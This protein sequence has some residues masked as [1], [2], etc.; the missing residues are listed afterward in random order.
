MLVLNGKSEKVSNRIKIVVD[1]IRSKADN[2][3]V[4]DKESNTKTM[5]ERDDLIKRKI[6]IESKNNF[7]TASG[8]ASSSSGLSCLSFALSKLF[9]V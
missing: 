3:E 8:M 1:A 5:I 7:P 2:V 4:F 9:G 6:V